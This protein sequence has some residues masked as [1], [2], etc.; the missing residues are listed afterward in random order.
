LN[1]ELRFGVKES[2]EALAQANTNTKM[3]TGDYRE[4]AIYVAHEAGIIDKNEV[5][6][7][8]GQ[9]LSAEDFREKV[10]SLVS[11]NV[12]EGRK[13]WSFNSMDALKIF[14]CE[15]VDRVKIVYRCNSDD[16]HMFVALM[17]VHG[18][19]CAVIADGINDVLALEESMVGFAMGENG[20]SVARD[21]SQIILTDDNFVSLFNSVKWG[22]NMMDNCRKFI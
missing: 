15:I 6:S 20:C 12:T 19:N 7:D 10:E 1:D 13:S 22:R 21:A 17:N 16:K 11:E 9:V 2:I 3:L 4:T 8:E 14:R 18:S 5:E